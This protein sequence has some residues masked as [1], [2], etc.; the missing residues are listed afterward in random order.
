[1]GWRDDMYSDD[2]RALQTEIRR[3]R[4]VVRELEE[5]NQELRDKLQKPKKKYCVNYHE[6][7]TEN[8][9]IEATSPEEAEQI[10]RERIQEGKED[11]PENC[12]DSW[13]DVTEIG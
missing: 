9:E 2:E 12:S 6:T 11:G 4:N 13:A 5:E 3:L 10:L 7:Y 1:M 8:Y